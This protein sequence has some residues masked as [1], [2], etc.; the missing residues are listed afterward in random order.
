[1]ATDF[2]PILF[3]GTFHMSFILQE[4]PS[5]ARDPKV[6][7]YILNS[8]Y[9]VVKKVDLAREFDA[10]EFLPNENATSFLRVV[11]RLAKSGRLIP[12]E[13]VT[14]EDSCAAE[15]DSTGQELFSFCP[16][17]KIAVEETFYPKPI[18]ALLRQRAW[19]LL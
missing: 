12:G 1:M 18:D 7:G 8:A 17:D 16:S 6:H 2:R 15:I 9:D 5:T 13:D 10:H 3:N 11:R 4:T 14:L 19:D